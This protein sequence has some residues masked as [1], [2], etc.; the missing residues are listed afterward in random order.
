MP[1]SQQRGRNG[2]RTEAKVGPG[3]DYMVRLSGTDKGVPSE[4]ARPVRLLG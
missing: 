1:I 2:T 4:A 3:L